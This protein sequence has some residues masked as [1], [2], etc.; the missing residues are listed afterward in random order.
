MLFFFVFI[1]MFSS[2]LSYG[3]SYERRL[4]NYF[5]HDS[6]EFSVGYFPDW[7]VKLIKN[8]IESFFEVKADRLAHR[9]GNIAIEIE[10]SGRPSGLT[11]TKADFYAIFV[12]NEKDDKLYV[13]HV[14]TLKE[15]IKN[16]RLVYGGDGKR[17]RMALLRVDDIKEY[18]WRDDGRNSN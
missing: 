1:K 7:D 15:K 16:C 10:C 6:Y 13:I 4:L 2:D 8:N 17:A 11:T 5:E 18:L 9:T 12:T 14:E 3:Q